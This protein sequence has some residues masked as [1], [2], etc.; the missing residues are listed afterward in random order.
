MTT[1]VGKIGP[2]DLEKDSW[3]Y[4]IDRLEQ[5][6]IAN[7]VEDNKKVA[8]LITVIGGDAYALMANL[9]MPVKPS[10]KTFKD[11]VKIMTDHLQPKPSLLAERFKFRRRIQSSDESVGEYAAAL[12]K[13]SKDCKFVGENLQENLRDQ[14]VCGLARD[15]IRQRLFAEDDIKFDKA[16]NLAVT[17][18]MAEADAALVEQRSNS[19][20]EGSGENTAPVHQI[21]NAGRGRAH[22][23][24]PND[25][26]S[27]N[28]TH[29]GA[30]G[31][32]GG[33]GGSSGKLHG[34]GWRIRNSVIGTESAKECCRVCGSQH[35]T[36]SCK[37]KMYVCRV[38]NKEGHLKRVCPNVKSSS[39]GVHHLGSKDFHMNSSSDSDEVNNYS[40]DAQRLKKYKPYFIKVC[41][42]SK[43]LLME[44]DTGSAVTCI[45]LEYYKKVFSNVP[46]ENSDL[47]LIYY[48]GE[49]V[50]PEGK[51]TPLV[52]YENI[53]KYLEL[54]IVRGGKTSLLG[55][56]WLVELGILPPFILVHCNN[57]KCEPFNFDVFSS[58]YR[59]VF[60]DGLGRF[61]GGTVGFRLRPDAR[62]VFLR[63]R[64]LAYALREPVE[65]ALEQLVRDGVL[66]PVQTSE[67]ATPIVP[68]MKKDGTIRVCGDFKLTLNKG[69]E[70]D[71]FPLPR[72][73]DLLT[74]LHG[75][76]KFTKLDLSQAY[77]QFELDEESKKYAVI[78]THKGL[79]RYNRLI[80]GLASSPGIFQRKLEQLF[81]DM[82]RVGVFLDDVIITG[83]NDQEHLTTLIEVFKRLQKY[84]LKVKKSKCTFFADSVTYLGFVISKEGVHTCP[85]KLEAIEKVSVPRN[86][87]ELRSFLGLVMYYA[88][89]VPNI[90]SLLAP[91]YNL[92]RKDVKYYWDSSCENAFN[93]VKGML[94]SS[95][96]LAHYSPELHLVLTCDAS[97]VGVGAVISHLI[98]DGTSGN[99]T[100]GARERPIAYASRSLNKAERG[101]SQIEKEALG[102]IFGIKKFH[103]YLFGRKFILRTDHKPL[104]TIFG[105]KVGIPV[106]A[107]SRMQ[108]WAVLLSGYVYDIEYVRSEKNAAD[109][110]SRLPT[111]EQA[112]DKKEVTYIN[113]IQNFLPITRKIVKENTF[114]DVTLQKV[115]LYLQSGWPNQYSHDD[116][117]KPYTSRKTELYLDRGCVVW[118]Y[119]LV[120]PKALQDAIL[121]ELHTG[122]MGIVKMKSIARSYV[123]WP[124]IDADIE[125]ICHECATCAAEGMAP[126][127]TAPQPW[128]YIPEPWSRL[129]L[130]F[131]G[132]LGGKMLCIDNEGRL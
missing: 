43:S 87:T 34:G 36:E 121:C 41:V 130:D 59:D 66:E 120:I 107:A 95:E 67:W 111:G 54:Y 9:C 76:Q 90:S 83:V 113:F 22:G 102:I 88:K 37:F 26:T 79:F 92:L 49:V 38:C 15:S 84:G 7:A 101:Y 132:P 100:E 42:N 47:N 108:R 69:L 20:R 14:F 60:G 25:S 21:R 74:K 70:V 68:V 109:A 91:L 85:D 104:V 82:P 55:R 56:Q 77:A 40:M 124:G 129:H 73:D 75:G 98:P 5:S 94:M 4:Y 10:T 51:I 125:R 119:R 71:R 131:L 61:T 96:V 62:P 33:G 52:T 110:L 99:G 24:A 126:P 112:R 12:K 65:R 114:K 17:L 115:V 30:A 29:G 80:Y 93:Q 23:R 31:R 45:S 118:G 32:G 6:F 16:F 28:S 19:R 63:A 123:W 86:T 13:L 64:P 1:A 106:M 72:V 103:Q 48:S 3:D 78:N 2:F 81:A 35:A 39:A 53:S 8:I 27:R 105:D 44:I 128:P 122:H 57:I 116:S 89:F 97:S 46:M 117:L 50:T 18:E 127:R 58:S 11:L